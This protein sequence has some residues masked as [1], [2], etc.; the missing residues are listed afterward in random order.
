MRLSFL[1]VKFRS[2]MREIKSALDMVRGSPDFVSWDT[3]EAGAVGGR[4]E[5]AEGAET[6]RIDGQ[7]FKAEIYAGPYSISRLKST[8]LLDR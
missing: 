4:A 5:M 7:G 6:K 1:Q 2:L 3:H 8:R